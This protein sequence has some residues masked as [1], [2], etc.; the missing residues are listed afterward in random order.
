MAQLFGGHPNWLPRCRARRLVSAAVHLVEGRPYAEWLPDWWSSALQ[1]GVKTIT[2]IPDRSASDLKNMR[3]NETE[4]V[5]DG[6]GI[7]I[8]KLW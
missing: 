1:L 3:N 8:G 2:E 5:E 4:M 6:N 7:E